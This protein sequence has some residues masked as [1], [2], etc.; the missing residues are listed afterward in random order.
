MAGYDRLLALQPP[1]GGTEPRRRR[2]PR[3]KARQRLGR[4]CKP[5]HRSPWLRDYPIRPAP[6]LTCWSASINA[7][8]R[9]AYL[10]AAALSDQPVQQQLLR[11]QGRKASG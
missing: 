11:A 8:A 2:E 7:D 6:R 10:R 4:C 3:P 9:E 1:R 5:W